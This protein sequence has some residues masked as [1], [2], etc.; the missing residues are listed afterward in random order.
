MLPLYAPGEYKKFLAAPY[1]KY[2]IHFAG[3]MNTE[4]AVF[5][6]SLPDSYSSNSGPEISL[7]PIKTFETGISSL[8]IQNITG[9][10][11]LE[12]G[13]IGFYIEY[14]YKLFSQNIFPSDEFYFFQKD[15]TEGSYLNF[16]PGVTTL[17]VLRIGAILRI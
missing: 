2:D 13:N 10:L 15:K 5:Y 12:G 9:G 6:P 14:T 4:Y 1:A 7:T 16:K 8:T 17:S 11:A 3:A